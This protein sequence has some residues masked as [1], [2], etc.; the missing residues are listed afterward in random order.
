MV[1]AL[2][3]FLYCA[4]RFPKDN[5]SIKFL[6]P[7][8]LFFFHDCF[9]FVPDSWHDMLAKNSIDQMFQQ[10]SLPLIKEC[11][12]RIECKINIL[13]NRSWKIAEMMQNFISAFLILHGRRLLEKVKMIPK[14]V[15]LETF[16][17]TPWKP[18]K[19]L[20]IDMDLAK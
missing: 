2:V 3:F 11:T 1:C 19:W 7:S 9:K 16:L 8:I 12:I 5:E 13:L 14:P 17:M 10:V 6:L 18:N 4:N 15:S 20:F